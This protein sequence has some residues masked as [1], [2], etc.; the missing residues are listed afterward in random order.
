M[1]GFGNKNCEKT[2]QKPV[3]VGHGNIDN[4]TFTWPTDEESHNLYEQKLNF[5]IYTIFITKLEC[6]VRV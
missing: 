6:L 4:V 2:E 5:A 1:I 3:I